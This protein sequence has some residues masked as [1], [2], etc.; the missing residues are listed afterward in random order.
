MDAKEPKLQL[1]VVTEGAADEPVFVLG[2]G[3]FTVGR[4]SENH[5]VLKDSLVSRQHAEIVCDGES[6]MLRDLGGKN[7]IRVNGQDVQDYQLLPG[8][9]ISIGKTELV[10][11]EGA[12]GS[13]SPLL[14]VKDGDG[15]GAQSLGG[16][17]LE[18][19]TAVF[20]HAQAK[21]SGPKS[22]YL[23][24]A[25]FYRF[26]E[27]V[28]KLDSE[29]DLYELVLATATQATGAERGFLGLAVEG[30]EH[31]PHG[32]SVVRFWDPEHGGKAQTM[33]MSESILSHIQRD[34]KA[35]LV[36]DVPDRQDFGMSVID[37]KIRSFIC[38]PLT[39]GER[40]LGLIYVD[41]RAA[42]EPFDRSDLEFVSALGRI[43]GMAIDTLRV[44][45]SLRRENERL[46]SLVSSAEEIIGSSPAMERV[47]QLIE[48]V[49][50]RD[51]SVLIAGE[52]GTGK[53][54]VARGIHNSSPRKGCPFVAV[55]CGAI[56]PQ[57]VESEFFGYEKG[58]FTGAAQTTEGKFDLANGGTLFLDE[59]G[60]MPLEMQVKILRALQER[61][62]YRVGGKKEISVD[63]RVISATNA[64]LKKAI[65]DGR[66]REDLYFRL[67]VVT[68]DVPPLRERGADV[69][70]IAERFLNQGG[71]G[72]IVLPKPTRECLRRYS[73]PGNIRE[74]RNAL[75]QAVILGDGK[76]ILPSDLPAEI[77][78]TGRGKMLFRIK[79]LS[80]V[81]KRYI[82]RVLDETEGNKAKA[83][84]LLGISRE[85]LYQKLK[86][87]QS[88]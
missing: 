58:A 19:S 10:L 71:E 65:E 48:K 45:S 57:L 47:I 39:S 76:R 33:E 3:H 21:D 32:L 11:E 62:F 15:S 78:K 30:R 86:L 20:D 51:T 29:E 49:A 14:V 73:W 2:E 31:D 66:F 24:L 67:A 13:T 75:E 84:Q 35:L 1:R 82:L 64:D 22:T 16:M 79:P 9:R 28:L 55:N 6:V 46:R 61:R 59:I 5:I 41:T 87:Y 36:R 60:D 27:Q 17:S 42:R 12:P 43:A 37:L 23:R 77:G 68:I 52:N 85:T 69:I 7:P 26:S 83:A 25:G 74:L 50:P 38:A 8:D 63:V 81:E 4:S 88:E 54:L 56:P 53:E 72:G 80:E 70:E 40:F 18:A 44:R 34:R